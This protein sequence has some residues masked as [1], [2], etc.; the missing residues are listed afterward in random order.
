MKKKGRLVW[1]FILGLVLLGGLVYLNRAYANIFEYGNKYSLILN[2]FPREY[3]VEGGRGQKEMLYV[4]LGD[5]LTYGVGADTLPETYPY[6][7]A[8]KN[9]TNY[10]S[11]RVNNLAMP[12]AVIEDV[13]NLQLPQLEGKNPQLFSLMIGTNDVHQFTSLE[14]FRNRLVKTIRVLKRNQIPILVI[15]IPY[16]GSEEVLKPP[17]NLWM[18]Q[19]IRSFNQVIK[20]VSQ[21]EGVKYID[22]YSL[23]KNRFLKNSD[24]YSKDQF[25]PSGKGYLLWG[26]IINANTSN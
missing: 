21:K 5:S 2:S 18:D 12:G 11:V 22:L 8:Q 16:L 23:T 24:L 26:E 19:R 7:I 15:N 10:Q 6:Q 3:L 20:E 4:A 17:Y 1:I 13:V 9:L 14:V 25:H